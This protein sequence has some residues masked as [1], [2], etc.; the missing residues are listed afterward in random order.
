MLLV[1][2]IVRRNVEYRYIPGFGRLTDLVTTIF[3]VLVLMYIIDRLR[4]IVWVSMPVQW[5][6]LIVAGLLIVVRYSLKR[7]TA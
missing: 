3:T 2:G 4:L 7:M 5:F 1:L 6:I